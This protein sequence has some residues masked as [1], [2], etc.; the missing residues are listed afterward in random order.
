[1]HAASF[2]YF[3]EIASSSQAVNL[4]YTAHEDKGGEA[5]GQ[6]SVGGSPLRSWMSRHGMGSLERFERLKESKFRQPL[7]VQGESPGVTL[8]AFIDVDDKFNEADKL[9]QA[10]GNSFSQIFL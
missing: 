1:M 2:L 7:V 4:L 9:S 3:L 6:E 10:W 5:W 8:K